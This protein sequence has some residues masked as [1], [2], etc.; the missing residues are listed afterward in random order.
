MFLRNLS[1]KLLRQA[2]VAIYKA[3]RRPHLDYG[4]IGYDKPHNETFINKIEK[5]QYDATL[6]ITGA[7]RGT[8][9]EKLYH[10]VQRG[11]NLPLES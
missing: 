7:I 3:F 10:S 5:A 1:Y 4:N 11:I 2:L 8:S 6:G 9:R